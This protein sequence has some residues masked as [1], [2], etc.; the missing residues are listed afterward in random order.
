MEKS[1]VTGGKWKK[2]AECMKEAAKITNR[3]RKRTAWW[4]ADIEEI[5]REKKAAAHGKRT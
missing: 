2:L 1:Q 3:Q 4:T 5:V